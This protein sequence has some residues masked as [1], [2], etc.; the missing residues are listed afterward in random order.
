MQRSRAPDRVMRALI[1][2]KRRESTVSGSLRRINTTAMFSRYHIDNQSSKHSKRGTITGKE[3]VQASKE[4]IIQLS[5]S[6]AT[7]SISDSSGTAAVTVSNSRK[8]STVCEP[9]NDVSAPSTLLPTINRAPLVSNGMLGQRKQHHKASG[10]R[11]SEVT[12]QEA[13]NVHRSTMGSASDEPHRLSAS[14]TTVPLR[15][16]PSQTPPRIDRYTYRTILDWSIHPTVLPDDFNIQVSSYRKTVPVSSKA[17]KSAI[18]SASLPTDPSSSSSSSSSSSGLS[19]PSP[20]TDTPSTYS[21][22]ESLNPKTTMVNRTSN[23]RPLSQEIDS[24]KI[25][26]TRQ[27]R[28]ARDSRAS[29]AW[30]MNSSTHDNEGANVQALIAQK[31]KWNDSPRKG[32]F[33]N[34]HKELVDRNTLN[35][36]GSIGVSIKNEH[37]HKS[38][39]GENDLR[40]RRGQNEHSID[41]NY[42]LVTGYDH[43]SSA[44][45]KAIVKENLASRKEGL[46]DREFLYS[47]AVILPALKSKVRTCFTLY[48]S[49]DASKPGWTPSTSYTNTT[50]L[51]RSHLPHMNDCL[52]AAQDAG[53][54]V[55]KTNNRRLEELSGSESHEGVVLEASLHSTQLVTALGPVSKD[56]HYQV[57]FDDKG[58]S[59]KFQ[60]FRAGLPLLSEASAAVT[61]NMVPSTKT[62]PSFPPIWLVMENVWD[63]QIMGEILRTAWY[64]G[65][66][67]VMYKQAR[68]A[69]P[70]AEVSLASAGALEHRP[71]YPIRNLMQFVLASKSN[72]WSIVGVQ[73]VFGS[74]WTQP[75]HTWPSEGVYRP[76]ILVLG[77]NGCKISKQVAKNCDACISVPSLSTSTTMMD[78]AG[79]PA[80]AGMVISKLMGGR[81]QYIN[82]ILTGESKSRSLQNELS[83]DA[84]D[85][86]DKYADMDEGGKRSEP[87]RQLQLDDNDHKGRSSRVRS[88]KL[89]W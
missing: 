41:N 14:T 48:Y 51:D 8:S 21:H 4:A 78:S 12:D 73:G 13:Y 5:A 18:V 36:E 83:E 7:T 34:E 24:E 16:S 69:L 50:V 20:S 87:Q 28:L 3:T 61:E 15:R 86:S 63:P 49:R 72:G 70:T 58:G 39:S 33:L 64:F 75:I 31:N 60:S 54:Q 79:G 71:L 44:T 74:K 53:I 43:G 37:R 27:Q 23:H 42:D 38:M 76:T 68:S 10:A 59:L 67:G 9:S 45:I 80:T 77:N 82:R 81:Y 26:D 22:L 47:P 65:V 57:M 35:K 55:I 88:N 89:L 11:G 2:P 66:D 46:Q 25:Q 56:N 84:E 6:T 52:R 40:L 1:I 19:L 85:D 17:L 62:S 29:Q 30:S 32:M